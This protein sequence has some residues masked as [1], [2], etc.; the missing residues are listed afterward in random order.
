MPQ[1][2]TVTTHLPP[3]KILYATDFLENSRL[4]LDYA[5]AFAHHYHARLLIVHIFCLPQPAIEVEALD[6]PS[7]SRLSREKRLEAFAA[8][9]RRAGVEADWKLVEGW[10]PDALLTQVQE[11]QPDLLFLG[12]HGVYHGLGHMLIGS[13]A[14]ATL[15]S[16]ECPTITVGRCVPGGIAPE[17]SPEHILYITDFTPESSAAAPY[18]VALSR[19][20]GARL[21]ICHLLPNGSGH[22][23]EANRR[24]AEQY[25]DAV[26]QY[27]PGSESSWC[28]PGDQLEHGVTKEEIL[29]RTRQ[30]AAGM[31]V[32][33]VHSESQFARRM[34]ATFAYE[35]VA[36]AASPVFTIRG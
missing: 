23:K 31:I 2:Q 17:S 15:L 3:K 25:C 26:R 8:A 5:V 16:A 14:E 33:G 4:A 9:V 30:D 6:P 20:F 13:N 34:H 18:A 27:V 21:D 1:L 22:N 7:L 29:Q 24:L 32:L 10:M 12:T 36:T 28:V 35:L 11:I 19:D